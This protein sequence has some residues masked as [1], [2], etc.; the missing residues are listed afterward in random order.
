VLPLSFAR[1][2]STAALLR[3][4]TDCQHIPHPLATA[5]S[6]HSSAPPTLHR[7]PTHTAPTRH[8]S[9]YD[10]PAGLNR[11][12]VFRNATVTHWSPATGEGTWRL[13]RYALCDIRVSVQ[14][15]TAVRTPPAQRHS[16][17][18]TCTA[19]AII[20]LCNINKLIFT[21]Q[22]VLCEVR[23]EFLYIIQSP[24]VFVSLSTL[25]TS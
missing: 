24:C 16:M 3:C 20:S 19:G 22:T 10:H 15:S 9:S 8:C 6:N 7:L 11:T 12:I 21:M 25:Y 18:G 14:P 4:C 1:F 13:S 5:V 17:Y 23:N 2:L